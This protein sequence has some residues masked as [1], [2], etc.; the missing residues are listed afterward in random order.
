MFIDAHCHLERCYYGDAVDAVVERALARGLTHFIAVGA[1]GVTAG[2]EEAVAL[3]GRLPQVFASVGIHPHEAQA[4]DAPAMQTIARLLEA[5]RVVALG[6]VGLDYYYDHSPREVQRRVFA[7]FL[8]M[9]AKYDKPVMLH[10]R[11]A[12]E[13]CWRIL[14]EVGLPPRGGVVHCFTGGPREAEAYLSRGMY[15]SIP[16]V[17]TFKTAEALREAVRQTPLDRLMLETDCPYLAPVPHRGKQNEPA[18]LLDTAEA[19][20]KLLDMPLEVLG[21]HTHANTVRFYGLG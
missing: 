9:A 18:F 2:A 10:V 11:D 13:D 5:P 15:L 16:G 12:H 17:V 4:A 3:A 21:R 20:A 19:V 14:D 8:Q 1:S 6:E 7:E